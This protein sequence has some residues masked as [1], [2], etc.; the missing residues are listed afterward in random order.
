MERSHKLPGLSVI[1][2]EFSRAF[3]GALEKRLGQT[4]GLA[5][6]ELDRFPFCFL[7]TKLTF[8]CASIALVR[9]LSI[10]GMHRPKKQRFSRGQLTVE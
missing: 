10:S 2:I 8:S 3:H 4:I 7:V 1:L 5:E 6:G 9:E